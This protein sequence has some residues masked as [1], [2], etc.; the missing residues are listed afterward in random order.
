MKKPK[1]FHNIS[2]LWQKAYVTNFGNKNFHIVLENNN[3][4]R[5]RIFSNSPNY[6]YRCMEHIFYTYRS[7]PFFRQGP[8]CVLRILLFREKNK[9][10]NGIS[11]DIVSCI[12]FCKDSDCTWFCSVLNYEVEKCPFSLFHY[13]SL[14]GVEGCAWPRG[15]MNVCVDRGNWALS[16]EKHE[17]TA[18]SGLHL[19]AGVQCLRHRWRRTSTVSAMP[20]LGRP[21]N[22]R[23]PSVAELFY[24][25]DPERSYVDLREIGHGSFGAVYCVLPPTPSPTNT[26]SHVQSRAYTL[27]RIIQQAQLLESGAGLVWMLWG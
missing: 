6:L 24:T 13:Y 11:R 22:L 2:C 20:R 14:A 3:V 26:L 12:Y 21:G 1:S 25:E 8:F 7:F 5:F 10:A 23:D 18:N 17:W 16:I 15:I 4:F 9:C 27:I 19:R